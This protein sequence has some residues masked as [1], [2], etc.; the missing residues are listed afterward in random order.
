[1]PT[2]RYREAHPGNCARLKDSQL[3]FIAMDGMGVEY[4]IQTNLEM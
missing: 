3:I 1:M 4:L 2:C